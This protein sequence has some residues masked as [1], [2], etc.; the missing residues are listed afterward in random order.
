MTANTKAVYGIL[1]F[2]VLFLLWYSVAANYDYGALAGTY[3]F[4]GN[5]ETCTLYLHPD[6][7]F[8][9]EISRSGEIRKSQG[10]WHRFGEA[11]VSFSNEFLS[12]PGEEMSA[13]GHA[14]GQFEKMF[15][16]FPSLVLAPLPDGPR[17]RKRLFR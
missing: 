1:T 10:Y 13:D 15:G 5:G 11:H 4:H 12:V 16:L 2:I 9:Q 3:V 7:S 14:H 6:R 17:F 8:V